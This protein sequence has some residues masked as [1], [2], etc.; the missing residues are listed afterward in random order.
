M[1]RSKLN[2]VD[3]A[4]SERVHKTAARG[5]TLREA[6]Y[7]NQSLF[8]LEMVIL[9]LHEKRPHVP[10]GR[11]VVGT[12]KARGRRLPPSPP[13]CNLMSLKSTMPPLPRVC[14]TVPQLHDDVRAPGQPG[15]ELPYRDAGH[16]LH[17]ARAHRRVHLHL[18]VREL[19]LMLDARQDTTHC[20]TT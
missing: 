20:R 17:G 5:Q 13:S 10:V 6:R 15:G 1:R 8:Y 3:L 4:G 11:W 9:A 12:G 14:M 18:S 2:L 19:R 7:I 16:H